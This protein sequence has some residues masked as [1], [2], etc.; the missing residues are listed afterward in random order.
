MN[1]L[2][3]AFALSIVLSASLSAQTPCSW[4]GQSGSVV[5]TC[6]KV[7]IGT[8]APFL[9][10][11]V[12][13]S[14][15]YAEV[16]IEGTSTANTGLRFI[17]DGVWKI[18][19][20]VGYVGSGKFTIWD[21]NAAKSRMVIDTAGRVGAGTASPTDRLHVGGADFGGITIDAPGVMKGRVSTVHSDGIGMTLNASYNGSGW[22][23]DD[24]A[25]DGW[26]M[27]LDGRA[28]S[29]KFSI[30]KIPAGAGIHT[31]EIELLSLGANG[32]L[33]A[34]N[35]AA[36]YQDVAE[37]VP[38]DTD[39]DA[40]TVVVLSDRGTNR[41]KAAAR[42]YDTRVAGV[43]SVA[44]GIVLGVESQDKE[45]IATTGRV[46]V[47]VDASASPIA[48]GDLLVTS[49]RD[50]HA[51]KSIPVD[52][53]GVAFHRPG[54]IVGKALEPLQGGQGEILVLL[55]LQ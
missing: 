10:L 29:N 44:P 21:I 27:K 36:K 1:R 11:H 6:G 48:V 22:T 34:V 40:G 8:T 54:T 35:I 24:P 2:R 41:V 18:G 9:D 25:R 43:V 30:W 42:E 33:T 51:M 3:W 38:S 28:G 37:W 15:T 39:L 26:F 46:R 49:E 16:T 23:L 20:N 12:K 45:Q 17:G 50:G 7:G 4:T 5:E 14:T 52:V 55:S 31:N 47:K 32:T 19:P 13:N 53:G